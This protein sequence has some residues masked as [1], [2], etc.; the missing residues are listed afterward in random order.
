MKLTITYS[1]LLFTFCFSFSQSYSGAE[2]VEYD[3]INDRWLVSNGSRIISDDGQGN[4]SYFG[5]GGASFGLEVMGN[6]VF[7]VQGSNIVGYDLTTEQQVTIATISGASFLNGMTSDGVHT[8]YVTDFGQDEIYS[9]DFSDFASPVT[10]QIVA[11]TQNTPNGILYDGDNNRL[12]Y[13][14]WNSNAQIKQVDLSNNQVSTIIT[15]SLSNIDGIDDDAAGNYYVSS[16]TPDRITKYDSNFENPE[17]VS[18]PSLSNPADIGINKATGIMGIPMG[19]S[20]VFVDLGVLSVEEFNTNAFN[21]TVSPNPIDATSTI[22]VF[23]LN[24]ESIT[25]QLLDVSGR[26][27]QTI[28]NR[29]GLDNSSVSLKN[30]NQASGIYFIRA[31]NELGVIT[32]KVIIK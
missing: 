26:V 23:N 1:I 24:S 17:T 4:L 19:S 15:T 7:G 14:S 32:K 10:T 18:T 5:T 27:V 6:T 21:F 31:S 16:W 30:I 20:V 28:S 9:I 8:I 25:I 2:S 29:I 12:I 3:P 11:N 22:S 13:T